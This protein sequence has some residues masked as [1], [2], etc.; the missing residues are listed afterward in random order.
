M[1]DFWGVYASI[2]TTF[3]LQLHMVAMSSLAWPALAVNLIA[4]AASI[5][6]NQPP[7]DIP[8][9]RSTLFTAASWYFVKTVGWLL[10]FLWLGT[11]FLQETCCQSFC[12]LELGY[13]QVTV[14]WSADIIC[15]DPF[16]LFI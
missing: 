13:N 10:E 9:E 7:P 4:V 8:F 14:I 6:P 1:L 5:W 15:L 2:P 11:R 16:S 3:V 12:V